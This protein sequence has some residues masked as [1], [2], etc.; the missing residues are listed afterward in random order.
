MREILFRGKRIDNGEW[1][2]GFYMEAIDDGTKMGF[3]VE[4]N[5]NIYPRINYVYK[6]L[7]CDIVDVI[8][9]TVGQYTGL[10]DK[11]SKDIFTGDIV[12]NSN[13]VP[14]EVAFIEKYAR[15]AFRRKGV[16]FGWFNPSYCKVIGNIHD[17]PEL[18]EAET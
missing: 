18:L 12:L 17:N 15:F 16:V 13:G 3:I 4:N 5:T 6:S 8:P 1:V 2:Y 14:Y 9:E 10:T 7:D 11:N